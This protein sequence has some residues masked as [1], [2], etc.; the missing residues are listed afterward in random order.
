MPQSLPSAAIAVIR[1]SP[2][3]EGHQQGTVVQVHADSV[4]RRRRPNVKRLYPNASTTLES[5]RKGHDQPHNG[6]AYF[7]SRISFLL[8]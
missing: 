7:S 5:G 4:K 3:G 2:P 8:C 6:V 1:P